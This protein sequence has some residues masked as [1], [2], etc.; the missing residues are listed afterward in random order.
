[1]VFVEEKSVLTK[2]KKNIVWQTTYQIAAIIIPFITAPYI[3]RVLG[4]NNSGIYSYT[5]SIVNYF[6]M[7]SMLGIDYYGN[8]SI[9]AVRDDREKTNLIFSQIFVA[10][11]IFASI[12]LCFYL[13]FAGVFGGIY[14]TLYFIQTFFIIGELLNINWLFAGLGEFKI[15]VIRNLAIKVLTLVAIFIFV[16][17][18][19]DLWSYTLIMS[20]G[21]AISTSAVW[22]VRSKYVSFTSVNLKDSLKH[23]KPLFKLYIAILASSI[24]RLI[25]KTMLGAMDKMSELGCYEY[26]EKIIKMPLAIITAVGVVMMSSSS[27]LLAN[28]KEDS[29]KKTISKTFEFVSIFCSLFVCGVLAYGN[30]FSTYYLGDEYVL[31][32]SILS[33]LSIGLVFSGWNDVLRTQYYIPKQKDNYYITSIIIAAVTNVILNLI[34]IP[35]LG[36][37]G[38]AIATVASYFLITVFELFFAKSDI[39]VFKLLLRAAPVLMLGLVSFLLSFVWKIVFPASL[40][41]LVIQIGIFSIEFLAVLVLYLL[42]TKQLSFVKQLFCKK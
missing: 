19:D 37:I 17:T 8:R 14:R 3:A 22:I 29:V 23:L 27:N 7:F 10:H 18:K 4:A 31:T 9:A 39:G 12:V 26:A 35:V 36:A 5:F 38:A 13:A 21:T 30:D 16:K 42:L 11:I 2:N 15:T 25:D 20:L 33:I 1:M 41:S 34:M 40:W 28:G 32:G 6:M 24:M